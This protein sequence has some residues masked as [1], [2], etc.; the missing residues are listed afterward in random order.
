MTLRADL[1]R[2]LEV[3]EEQPATNLLNYR[4]LAS[5]LQQALD[6]NPEPEPE[7]EWGVYAEGINYR[8]HPCHNEDMA[9]TRAKHYQELPRL[10]GNVKLM[11]RAMPHTWEEA[12]E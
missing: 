2:L 9:K 8:V 3:A 12:P 10:Y 11:R 7:W 5:L 1:E 6:Q 4:M